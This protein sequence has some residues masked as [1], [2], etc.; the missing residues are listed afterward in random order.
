MA[1]RKNAAL[2]ALLEQPTIAAAAES[3]GISQPTLFRLL[4]DRTFRE[5]YQKAKAD[6]VD[7]ALTKLHKAAAGAVTVLVSIMEDEKAPASVRVRAASEI[8]SRAI[9]STKIAAL[10]ARIEALEDEAR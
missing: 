1:D 6:L 7:A 9:D 2:I 8:L 3:S 10:E 4:R 5:Q